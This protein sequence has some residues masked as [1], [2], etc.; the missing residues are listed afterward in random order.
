MAEREDEKKSV[1]FESN[2][3]DIKDIFLQATIIDATPDDMNSIGMLIAETFGVEYKDG[4]IDCSTN[5]ELKNCL[6]TNK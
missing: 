4:I 6:K 1:T 3:K 5:E 2:K